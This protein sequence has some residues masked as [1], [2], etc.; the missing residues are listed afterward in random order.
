MKFKYLIMNNEQLTIYK[1]SS[2]YKLI[3]GSLKVC[4]RIIPNNRKR[5]KK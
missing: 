3:N 4:D 1:I 5:K 2:F